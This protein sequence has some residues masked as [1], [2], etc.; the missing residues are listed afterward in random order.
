MDQELNGKSSPQPETKISKL[1]CAA[2]AAILISLCGS[3]AWAASDIYDDIRPDAEFPSHIIYQEKG[4]Y[5][6]YSFQLGVI[7]NLDLFNQQAENYG[8]RLIP[9]QEPMNIEIVEFDDNKGGTNNGTITQLE[10][11]QNL[12]D[13]MTNPDYTPLHE[14]VHQYCQFGWDPYYDG[15]VLNDGS[16]QI[17]YASGLRFFMTVREDFSITRA[18][19]TEAI[20]ASGD[21]FFHT[22]NEMA[23]H[24]LSSEMTGNLERLLDAPI[25]QNAAA[26]LG[27]S[28]TELR[29]ILYDV[30]DEQQAL[31][32][33]VQRLPHLTDAADKLAMLP[34]FINYHFTRLEDS[35]GD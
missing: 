34:F 18:D 8:C 2:L 31:E 5:L 33:F 35:T 11:A 26:Y 22:L 20:V 7:A 12:F 14:A 17:G 15:R 9:D 3:I 29:G 13:D 25:Y 6:P 1:G 4:A 19:G 16:M 28:V 27:I 30:Q 21:Y 10:G 24:L 32:V 23:A